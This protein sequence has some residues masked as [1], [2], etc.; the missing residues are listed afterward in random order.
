MKYWREIRRNQPTWK[1]NELLT[2]AVMFDSLIVA[3]VQFV[4]MLIKL[5][6]VLNQELQ[7]LY[8]KATTMLLEWTVP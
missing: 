3:Y 2:H 4:I 7:H 8:S 1:V 6:K 5:Q